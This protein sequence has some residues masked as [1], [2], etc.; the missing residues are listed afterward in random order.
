GPAE[1]PGDLRM[2]RRSDRRSC[3]GL[4]SLLFLSALGAGCAG[5][6]TK[7]EPPLPFHVAVIPIPAEKAGA[8]ATEKTGAS[9]TEKTGASATEK[10]GASATEKTGAQATEKQQ[11]APSKDDS[12]E[13]H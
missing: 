3:L 9:A 7:R 12:K 6:G 1:L 5:A 11:A 13:F 10:T 2:S 4:A 8:S